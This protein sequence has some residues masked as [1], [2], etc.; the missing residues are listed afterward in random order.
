MRRRD[1]GF[2][3]I[4]VLVALLI[5]SLVSATAVVGMRRMARTDLRTSALKLSGAIRYLFDR[6]SATGKIHRLVFDFEQGRYW[7]E[8]SDDR[9]YMP[10]DRE[11]EETRQRENEQIAKE[12]EE[13]KLKDE[14]AQA[15]GENAMYDVTKYQPQEYRPK[16][17]RFN[18][19][20]EL[21]I[22]PVQVKSGIKIYGLYTPRLAEP[23]ATGRGYIYFFPLGSTEAAMVYL[24]DDRRETIY[25]LRVHP[26]TGRVQVLNRFLE[27]PVQEHMDD[28]GN[29]IEEQ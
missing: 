27:P 22:K 28:E 9:Y 25:T 16:R 6:A 18:A 2:T 8:E 3:L 10:R 4:E 12:Q 24:S 5:I 20:K 19:F 13:Q 7:A 11:N 26:L 15:A 29:R 1:R 23:Q 14:E 17:A 21:A